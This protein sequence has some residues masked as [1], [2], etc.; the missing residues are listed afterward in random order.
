M[1]NWI[2][3][4]TAMVALVAV[5]MFLGAQH[6]AR[7]PNS[8]VGRCARAVFNIVDSAPEQPEPQTNALV[9]EV[10]TLPQVGSINIPGPVVE[11]I[12]V[13]TTEDEPPLVTPRLSP[14]IVAAIE[15]LRGEE[16]SEAPPRSFDAPGQTLRMPYADEST[17]TLPQPKN[18]PRI[19]DR[20]DDGPTGAGF[21]FMPRTY[22]REFMDE[23]INT[24]N[25]VLTDYAQ[26]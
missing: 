21:L 15:R 22:W 10:S 4:G 5:G 8:L 18:A 9:A 20:E 13:S 14:E 2:W 25:R 17:E 23:V 26:E 24:V 16:E 1:R 11:P 3:S 6:A 12:V 7:Y 19:L